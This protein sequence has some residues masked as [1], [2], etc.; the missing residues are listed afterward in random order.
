M[1]ARPG[2][3]QAVFSSGEIDRMLDNRTEQKAYNGGLRW[4]EGVEIVPQ[5][6]LTLAP[7]TRHVGDLPATARRLFP[8]TDNAGAASMIVAS[9]SAFDVWTAGAVVAGLATPYTAD[10]LADLDVCQQLDTALFWHGEVK[11]RRVL[12]TAAGGWMIAEAPLEAL[13]SYDY[14]ATYTN[15][16]P[17]QWELEFVEVW[18]AT[19]WYLTVSKQDTSSLQRGTTNAETAAAI[20]AAITALPTVGDG[21]TVAALS[22]T[23]FLITFGGDDNAGDDWAVSAT[24]VNKADAAIVA[25]HKTV[26]VEPGEPVVSDDRGWPTTGVFYN[27][28]LLMSGFKS[29][30]NAWIY[31][32][33]G[34]YY[35]FDKRLDEANG[36]ALVPMDI[37]GGEKIVKIFAVRNLLF[38][39][40]G[41]EYWLA[42]RTIS[43]T[44]APTHVLCSSYGSKAGRPVIENEG[45]ALFLDKGGT[46]IGE[47][48]YTDV[49][50][51][52]VTTSISLVGAH[53]F[54]GLTGQAIQR[55]ATHGGANRY[56][57]VLDDGEIRLGTLLREQE[58]TGFERWITDGAVVDVAVDGD[59]LAFAIV[60]RPRGGGAT[61]SLE[62]FDAAALL[63]GTVT[64]SAVAGQSTIEGLGIHEGAEV[65]AIAED[66]VF[67]PFTV[68]EGRIMLPRE[69]AAA[70]TVDVGRWT[71]PAIET[72]PLSG[73]VADTV[74]LWRK[75]RIHTVRLSVETTTSIA[76]A[77]NFTKASPDQSPLVAANGRIVDVPLRRWGDTADVGELAAPVTGWLTVPGLKGYADEPT[78]LITQKRPGRLTIK[79]IIIEATKGS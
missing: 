73:L 72:L 4:A 58:I 65:W 46:V 75:T 77:A 11:P 13:P 63:D 24:V 8:F 76:V 42:D 50:G 31:S 38:F 78:V 44:T 57:G 9:A 16:I 28:R 37:P 2:K 23:K 61:R 43:K 70:T 22:D 68:V 45:G 52:F 51:N 26:G 60:E 47:T 3:I 17:A 6:G 67:G 56:F 39:T 33:E 34:D 41:G 18:E 5:G 71:P 64:I 62:R 25:Y 53:L 10:R 66:D 36:S 15:G 29:L 20:Q 32:I 49:Q 40:T 12:K 79:S 35:N 1:P 7:R 74:W 54:E 27:Q 69:L 30:P 48:R 19:V 55:A 14:G 21:V 59:N